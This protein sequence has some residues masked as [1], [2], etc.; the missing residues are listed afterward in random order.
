MAWTKERILEGIEQ[1]DAWVWRGV[2]AIYERQTADEQNEG[3][4]RYRNNIGFNGVDAEIL[5]S[6]AIQIRRW[7]EGR[8]SYRKPL[9]PKQTK[10]ARR[11]IRKYA[12][13]LA[14]IAN[15]EL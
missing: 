15:G 11:K 13:Q 10:L 2:E 9:S 12:G 1:N 14:R 7:K 6:F 3:Q 8:S 4:T 5:T